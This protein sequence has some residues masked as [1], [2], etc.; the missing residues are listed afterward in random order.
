M[1]GNQ[2]DDPNPRFGELGG[3]MHATIVDW[4]ATAADAQA[5][6]SAMDERKVAVQSLCSHPTIHGV[7]EFNQNN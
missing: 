2:K 6:A 3:G 4:I 7:D 1:S 5:I